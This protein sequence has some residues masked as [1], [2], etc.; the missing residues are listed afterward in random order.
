MNHAQTS[1]VSTSLIVLSL[2][3]LVDIGL[4]RAE[5]QKTPMGTLK[6]AGKSITS[7][8]LQCAEDGQIEEF[9]RPEGSIELPLGEYRVQE[10]QLEGG[11]T[12]DASMGSGRLQDPVVVGQQETLTVGA[13]L[14]QTINIERQG[15]VLTMSYALLGAGGEQY[16]GGDRSNP[17]RFIIYR[18]DKEIASGQFEFG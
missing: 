15:R 5:A 12:Y 9:R 10:V 6:L 13:P 4:S 1:R 11:Y 16:T 7:L 3:F 17:P 14:K 8:K 2:L 18:G